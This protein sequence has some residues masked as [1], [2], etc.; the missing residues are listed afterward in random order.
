MANSR[1][2]PVSV[3]VSVEKIY[4]KDLSLENPGA[5]QTFR[6][7]RRRR[8]RSGLRTRADQI[9]PDVY[10]VVLTVTVTANGGRPHAVPRRG[11]AGRD[12]HGPGRDRGNAAAGPRD[13]L[14]GGA[15]P[16]RARDDRGR[17]DA[18]RLPAGASPADQLRGAVLSSSSRRNAAAD[19]RCR[20]RRCVTMAGRTAALAFA[21]AAGARAAARALRSSAPPPTRRPCSTTRRRPGE[22]AVR[23]RARRAGRGDRQRRRLDQGPRPRRHDRLDRA[24]RSPTSACPPGARA[25]GRRARRP[26][27]GR[28]GRLSRR[29]ERAARAGRAGDVRRHDC[30]AR[31]GEGPPPR[32]RDRVRADLAGVRLSRRRDDR[33]ATRASVAVV[34]AGAWGTAIAAHLAARAHAAPRVVLGRDRA[35]AGGGDRARAPERDATC[36]ASRCRTRSTSPAISRSARRADL[37]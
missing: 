33:R 36:P 32:R 12:L 10:E 9:E 31:L 27:R 1:A 15:V 20:R 8:S 5:P 7:T 3:Q 26:R 18:R 4:V 25:D 6:L 30:R 13:P 14:P 29:A 35:N 23:L 37:V 2:S 11:G 16:V 24:K 28:A 34:G 21:L 19:A 22:A 17:D